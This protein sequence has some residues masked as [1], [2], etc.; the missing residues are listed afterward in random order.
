M[1]VSSRASRSAASASVA[2][3]GLAV[4]ARLQPAPH[5]RVE[6]EHRLAVVA[7]DD[8]RARGQVIGMAARAAARP[9]ARRDARGTTS[10]GRPAC[11]SG[12]S[13][14]ASTARASACRF[15]RLCC[16][17]PVARTP[18]GGRSSSGARRRRRAAGRSRRRSPRPTS[19]RSSSWAKP[20]GSS[21][22]AAVGIMSGCFQTASRASGP[23]RSRRA[24]QSVVA[25]R[26]RAG[27]EL[28]A[29][30]RGE[31]LLGRTAGGTATAHRLGE[32]GRG[33]HRLASGLVDD[34]VD[35]ALDEGEQ[36][37]EALDRVLLL[38]GALGLEQ[39]ALHG[40]GDLLRARRVETLH[41]RLDGREV[42]AGAA[43]ELL[44][45]ADE[46]GAEPGG[47][48]EQ[49]V[50]GALAQH[51]VEQDVRGRVL[52]A[53]AER[54]DVVGEHGRGALGA[55]RQA[56]VGGG[57]DLTG[58]PGEGLADLLAEHGAAGLA[59]D[60]DERPGHG[61][62]LLGDGLTHGADDV[63][64]DRQRRAS[65]RWVRWPRSTRRGSRPT[66]D[67]APA[68]TSVTRSS[69]DSARRT[70]S[71]TA[72]LWPACG[73]G[74]GPDAA[75]ACR[76]TSLAIA[77]ST[78][79]RA[80]G[81]SAASGPNSAPRSGVWPPAPP[82]A[83]NRASIG[84]PGEGV[85]WSRIRLV[86][87]VRLVLVGHAASTTQR[88]PSIPVPT[89]RPYDDTRIITDRTL[90]LLD[91]R[92]SPLSLDEVFAAVRDPA[93]GGIALFV[94]TVREVDQE[95]SGRPAVATA[96]IPRPSTG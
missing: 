40:L 72:P 55:E 8:E 58:Q 54:L 28:E 37:L 15:T 33:G 32:R 5:D 17:P 78:G 88:I 66:A 67:V 14:A 48:V 52:E 36:G 16:R 30:E 25:S 11:R 63:L 64:G 81:T 95:Q 80:G 44:D 29:D 79:R 85:R 96:R 9:G 10:A 62:G 19:S 77:K 76:A 46:R 18:A 42:D 65:P 31:G 2:S 13:H 50:V 57:D 92:D 59:Q 45:R 35:P 68:G 69:H 74:S 41:R 91:I 23:W 61:L 89:M 75:R 12:A 90:R 93:A 82:S 51:D 22:S 70:A 83:P 20:S 39:A 86:V 27:P 26:M 47:V 53:L 34:L 73:E 24:A 87:A 60:A 7:R 3:S 38:G 1:P 84:V 49:A 56:D 6:G 71:S 4:P 94:G 43:A 21:R